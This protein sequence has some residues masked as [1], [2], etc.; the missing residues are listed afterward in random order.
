METEVGKEEDTPDASLLEATTF[1]RLD[2]MLSLGKISHTKV[3]KLKA[4]YRRLS[5]EVKRAQNSEA[6]L[7]EKAKRLRADLRKLQ[8]ELEKKEDRGCSEEPT[9]ESG[10]LR[11]QLLQA[12]DQL[13][14]AEDR[15]YMT[16]HQLKWL[17]E[18]KRYLLTE[19]NIPQELDE[20]ENGT[21]TLQDKCEKLKKEVVHRQIEIRCLKD[22]MESYQI[23][24]RIEEKE[25]EEAMKIMQLKEAE[26]AELFAAPEQILKEIGEKRSEREAAVKTLAAMDAQC[27]DVKQQTKEVEEHN[28]LLRVQ[29][30]EL[31]KELEGLQA[32]V[33]ASQ[34]KCSELQKEIEVIREEEAELIGQRG[35]LE[36]K[37]QGIMSEQKLLREN[38]AVQLKEKKRQMQAF[39][40]MERA[41]AMATEQLQHTQSTCADLQ[42]QLDALPKREPAQAQR[43][44]LQKEVDALKASVEKQLSKI[45]KVS[46]IQ[47]QSGIIQELLRQSDTLREELHHL[48]CL[49]YIKAEERGQKHREMLRAEQMKRHVEQ[50]LREKKLITMHHSKL[51]AMLQRRVLQYGQLCEG[52]TEEKNKYIK[53]K[54]S[55]SQTITEMMEHVKVL[56]NQLEIQKSI[57]IKKDKLLNKAQKKVSNSNKVRE[58][59]RDTIN[60][61][62]R[63]IR[64]AIQER[65]DNEVELK[66]LRQTI[67]F[68]EQTLIDVSKNQ[69]VAVQRRNF[70]GI[71]LLEREE[72]LFDYQ[73]KVNSQEAAITQRD[74]EM[75]GM[76]KEMRDLKV[77]ISEEKRRIGFKKKEVMV[78]KKLE[79]ELIMLQLEMLEARD[80]TLDNLTKNTNY[81]ELKG[82]DLSS[83]ELVKKIEKLE[84]D[85]AERERQVLEKRL[86]VDQVTRLSKNLQEQNEICKQD[87]LSLA[88]KL[89]ELRTQI[90]D[91]SRRLMATS[92]EL[93]MKQ[94]AVLCLQQEVKERELQMDR[95]Q[96]R[97]EQGLPPCPEMEE[98]WRRMLRDKKRRQRD[99]EERERLADNDEWKLLPNGQYTTAESRPDAYIPHEDAL[100]LPKPYGAQAPFKP[101]QPGAN[102]RH[103]RKPTHLKPLEL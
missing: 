34:S 17:R 58:K 42:A 57:V 83:P 102:M 61:V 21:I 10:K 76:G 41:L 52:I 90:I 96:R 25:L 63:Q 97:L 43:M 5:D 88:K 68:Q 23:Q 64:Q 8:S 28:D 79:E 11:Q 87:K 47:Q 33:E 78:Q 69:E 86:L 98:E 38:Y 3:D 56:Q 100:P 39:K 74:A 49:T 66:R 40:R 13:R 70:L 67:S 19:N 101:T 50:E 48:Q 31:A 92:A 99:K 14:A 9:S 82:C 32:Q 94:A 93:S 89:N 6:L 44:A 59:L 16:Q 29:K 53:L 95:C 77:L 51:S 22:D 18:E 65:E 2:E 45:P 36:M 37:M 81:K 84:A 26:K 72:V 60:K 80:Q 4:I 20:V 30:E 12:F 24:T 27:S 46:Q 71:Q 62:A 91:T 1:Q 54:Q 85:F 7:F 35:I 55:A 73:E 15:D 103:I 75:Q